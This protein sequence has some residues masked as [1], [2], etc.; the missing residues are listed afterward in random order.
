[1]AILGEGGIPKTLLMADL[2]A[3]RGETSEARKLYESLFLSMTGSAE[4]DLTALA[5]AIRADDSRR[6]Q[7]QSQSLALAALNN[8][9]EML[10]KHGLDTK[11][12][13]ALARCVDAVLPDSGEVADTL[14][15]ALR[16]NGDFKEA[17]ARAEANPNLLLGALGLAEVELAEQRT[18]AASAAITQA[19]LLMMRVTLP[20]RTL[21]QR[22]ATLRSALRSA[23]DDI[24]DGSDDPVGT[25]A[26]SPPKVK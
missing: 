16:V 2:T 13:L 18:S 24:E 14:V 7:Y 12:A 8:L 4:V 11:E 10:L 15:R 19:E 3:A 21:V 5:S 17:R 9:A 23:N 22:I 26:P 1:L 6:L 20:P 25:T